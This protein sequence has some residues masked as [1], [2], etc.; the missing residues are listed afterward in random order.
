MSAISEAEKG[1]N[2]VV[3]EPQRYYGENRLGFLTTGTYRR[4]RH[5]PQ[6]SNYDVWPPTSCRGGFQ[7]RP[8]GAGADP[9]FW[10]LRFPEGTGVRW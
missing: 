4:A 5:G 1:W 6:T 3:R 7:T 9:G 8:Y 2:G 10:G